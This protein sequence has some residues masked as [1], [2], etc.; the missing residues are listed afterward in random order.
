M[1]KALI[2][3]CYFPPQGGGGVQRTAKFVKYLPTYGWKPIVLTS[4]KQI[5]PVLDQTLLED[6]PSD[7]HI[8]RTRTL[9]PR[10]PKKRN[11]IHHLIYVISI[12]DFSIWWIPFAVFEGFKQIKKEKINVIYVTGDPFSSYFIGCILKFFTGKPLIIDFR[13]A[14]ILD[15]RRHVRTLMKWRDQIEKLM[16]KIC[17]KHSEKVV[18]ATPSMKKDFQKYF[19]SIKH[20]EKFITI[21]NG[22]D[23]EDMEKIENVKKEKNYFNLVYTGS[24]QSVSRNP[25]YLFKALCLLKT[26]NPEIY[27]KIRLYLVG[28]IDE[29]YKQLVYKYGIK[30]C[31]KLEG[32]VSHNKSLG[33]LK[34]ADSL[35]F[36]MESQN[37][38]RQITS[39]KIF[40]Y[41]AF[42]K[43]ILALANQDSDASDIIKEIGSGIFANPID[44]KDILAKLLYLYNLWEKNVEMTQLSLENISKYRREGL[45]KKLADL[46]EKTV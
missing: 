46:F 11:M 25:S 13:D 39:G 30:D 8:I 23:T 3:S 27:N 15:P 21:T 14:W 5:I 17:V 32:Y 40:E 12:P 20:P 38:V 45:T 28:N 7:T 6:I 22:F 35:V 1:K 36:I 42:K 4:K 41:I 31:V 19:G 33:Y 43:P 34:M 16:F 2:I 37:N 18:L 26:D 10:I 24:L 29:K 9:Q 44:E